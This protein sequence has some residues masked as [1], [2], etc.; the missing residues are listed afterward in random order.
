[1]FQFVFVF[2]FVQLYLDNYYHETI[3][4][5]RYWRLMQ[6]FNIS[7]LRC[8]NIKVRHQ[9]LEGAGVYFHSS[10]SIT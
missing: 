3:K 7:I 6:M 2:Q 4:K 9:K 5:C 10:P 8:G 1:M